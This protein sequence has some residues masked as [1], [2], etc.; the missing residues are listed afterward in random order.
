ME[1]A[2]RHSDLLDRSHR[3]AVQLL[4]TEIQCG[5]M[6]L[7]L[8]APT[9]MAENRKRNLENARTAYE[10]V[11]RLLPPADPLPGEMLELE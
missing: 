6:F 3:T 4:M 7:D 8:A 9:E 2:G 5:L 10:M 1:M 11:L